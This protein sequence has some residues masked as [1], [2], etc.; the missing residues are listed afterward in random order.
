MKLFSNMWSSWVKLPVEY[1]MIAFA[2]LALIFMSVVSITFH[3][4]KKENF[5]IGN[6]FNKVKNVALGVKDK[7]VGIVNKQDS[8]QPIYQGRT[9]TSNGSMWF[10]SQGVDSGATDDSK[11]CLVSP[12]GPQVWREDGGNWGWYCP[13]GSTPNDSSDWNQK[14]VQGYSTKQLIDGNWRCLDSEMTTG[15]DWSNSDWYTAQ[16]Q[17]SGVRAYT[18]RHKIGGKWTCPDGYIDTGLGWDAPD[19]M[20]QCIR[21]T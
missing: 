4:R 15:K 5:S 16:Q 12:L 21:K 19:G 1:K 3:G 20:V 10:C 6:I 9:L 14:C 17:C 11:A 2:L 8:Y 7:V 13:R 18:Q